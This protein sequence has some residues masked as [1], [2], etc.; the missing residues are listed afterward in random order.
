MRIICIINALK[1]NIYKIFTFLFFFACI[2]LQKQEA[3]ASFFFYLNGLWAVRH[4]KIPAGAKIINLPILEI[5]SLKKCFFK[6]AG[7]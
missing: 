1:Q 6:G 7:C 2:A 5:K 3:G 4:P